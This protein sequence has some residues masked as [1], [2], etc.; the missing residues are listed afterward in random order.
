ME[1]TGFHKDTDIFTIDGW[2]NVSELKIGDK[3]AT[4]NPY[5]RIAEFVSCNTVQEFDYSGSM[6]GSGVNNKSFAGFSIAPDI[7]GLVYL[8]S[9]PSPGFLK[10]KYLLN[11][12]SIFYIA[13][14]N[15]FKGINKLKYKVKDV[16]IE[17]Y[18]AAYLL[19]IIF[20]KGIIARSCIYFPL[21]KEEEI[22]TK[23]KELLIK[24][25]IKFSV[26]KNENLSVEIY[27]KSFCDYIEA[28]LGKNRY[29]RFISNKIKNLSSELLKSFVQGIFLCTKYSA[30]AAYKNN[31]NKCINDIYYVLTKV[32][33]RYIFSFVGYMGL[34]RCYESNDFSYNV[35]KIR[36]KDKIYSIIIEPYHTLLIR[37]NK[38]CGFWCGDSK[39]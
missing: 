8:D 32:G 30:V 15:K 24:L 18:D 21:Y 4:L 22:S 6:I 3:L 16:F 28:N 29:E 37:L 39:Q 33:Y 10:A 38:L 14:I 12:K 25:G 19:G 27:S 5:T 20:A 34:I 2:K 7:I 11:Q 9:D 35:E 23:I 13:H 26:K 36:Y 31:K 1:L 17:G